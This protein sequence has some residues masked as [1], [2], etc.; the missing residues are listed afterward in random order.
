MVK[1]GV[2]TPLRAVGRGVFAVG[3]GPCTSGVVFRVL[4]GVLRNLTVFRG[5]AHCT[6]LQ[7]VGWTEKPRKT[8]N[9]L[10]VATRA[11]VCLRQH[12]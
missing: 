4:V 8:P 3:S 1:N 12:L 2:F 11:G 7:M 9:L 6:R 10:C 5:R